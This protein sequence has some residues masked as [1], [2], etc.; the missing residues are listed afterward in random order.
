MLESKNKIQNQKSRIKVSKKI[1]YIENSNYILEDTIYK[2]PFSKIKIG[3]NKITGDK[4]AVKIVNKQ[5]KSLLSKIY[6]NITITR[7]LHHI[8]ILQL[9]ENIEAN[10][11]F[12][13]IMEYYKKG[14]L[15]NYIAVKKNLSEKEA[16][17]YFQQI[18]NCLE[19]LNLCNIS[20]FVIR[21]ENIY[22][23]NEN[24]IKISILSSL[25]NYDMNNKESNNNLYYCGIILYM[26]LVG[27]SPLNEENQKIQNIFYPNNISKDAVNLIN[28]MINI[29]HKVKF[30]LNEIKSHP[31]FNLIKAQM[32]P[33]IIYNIHKMPIDEIILDKMES[34]GYKKLL[35]KKSIM[36]DKYDSLMG[37]YL[38]ILKQNI[39]EGKES[40][41][42]LFSEKF[43]EYINDQRNWIDKSKINEQL[44]NICNVNNISKNSKDIN[45]INNINKQSDEY[46]NLEVPN[47]DKKIL[48]VIRKRNKEKND[49]FINESSNFHDFPSIELTLKD[50]IS[51]LNNLK[52]E[53]NKNDNNIISKAINTDRENTSNLNNQLLLSA[54]KNKKPL[55]K[56][57]DINKIQNM[58]YNKIKKNKK[59]KFKNKTNIDEIIDK[60]IL[61]NK[62]LLSK[63]SSQNNQNKNHKNDNIK[64]SSIMDNIDQKNLALNNEIDF[65]N[66][67][68]NSLS[69]IN[70]NNS[71]Y[72][73]YNTIPSKDI[74]DDENENKSMN[75]DKL[76]E[77]I[78]LNGKDKDYNYNF[79]TPKKIR[80]E[81][82]KAN[83]NIINN[84]TEKK[85]YK[86]L[87][88][89]DSK[90]F[91]A[92]LESDIK[93]KLERQLIDNIT[94]FE[95][96]LNILDD[97]KNLNI[98][99]DSKKLNI[100]TFAHKLIQTT[101]FKDYFPKNL[102]DNTKNGLKKLSKL[103]DKYKYSCELMSKLMIKSSSDKFYD[104]E[105]FEK[106][107]DD[108]DDK[109]ICKELL[110][111]KYLSVFIK[112]LKTNYSDH[113]KK[114]R[115]GRSI[116]FRKN[117]LFE[118]ENVFDKTNNT[119]LNPKCELNNII[120]KQIPNIYYISNIN[121]TD[122]NKDITK[123]FLKRRLINKYS[124]LKSFSPNAITIKSFLNNSNTKR[125][126]I[127][128]SFNYSREKSVNKN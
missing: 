34:M 5:N 86:S 70:I 14:T 9:Y 40:I 92:P 57:Y 52:F 127:Y 119:V 12:Y 2:N 113:K 69:K 104:F 93:I 38:L 79:L 44:Y 30:D 83:F 91:C 59:V 48:S 51:L 62:T 87:R 20:K 61:K 32:R 10:D 76:N 15:S 85:N 36:E 120:I 116:N 110:K 126:N 101:I 17:I 27:K 66:L 81:F 16:C 88:N 50:D 114:N 46:Y 41:S 64:E 35:C 99:N 77:N 56:K 42:D 47:E 106:N 80:S 84:K 97:M 115:R 100:L 7:H 71:Y 112:A 4:V 121:D 123:S 39:K 117:N 26:M 24:R 6:K 43:I 33:G 108:K 23:D 118:D 1:K 128:N 21:P 125:P 55:I 49:Y 73:S 72:E 67:S 94:K 54:N 74:K 82:V 103:Q 29:N 96:D 53:N 18:I 63:N 89:D 58:K 65:L 28:I 105:N 95:R 60:R 8:N 19:Y 31:W 68:V 109:I 124:F 37:I 11:K 22:L 107:F 25:N 78:N 3:I 122:I 111:N 102:K 13:I 75:C 98:D 90:L 45:N